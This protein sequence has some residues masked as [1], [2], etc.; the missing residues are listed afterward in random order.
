MNSKMKKIIKISNDQIQKDKQEREELLKI[1]LEFRRFIFSEEM[2]Q[3]LSLYQPQLNY[4]FKFYYKSDQKINSSKFNIKTA[5][6]KRSTLLK[7]LN[8]FYIIPNIISPDEWIILLKYLIRNENIQ[9]GFSLQEFN[10]LLVRMAIAG[11][12][13]IERW[14]TI[15]KEKIIHNFIDVQGIGIT[16]IEEFFNF[17]GMIQGIS[18]QELN[19]KLKSICGRSQNKTSNKKNGIKNHLSKFNE[20]EESNDSYFSPPTNF[21]RKNFNDDSSIRKG[22][23]LLNFSLDNDINAL[24]KIKKSSPILSNF[25]NYGNNDIENPNIQVN[26]SK[27]IQIPNDELNKENKV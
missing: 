8:D 23:N 3:L 15:D 2:H 7:L 27:S 19:F 5:T 22:S 20:S 16:T 17:M 21:V 6:L 18:K 14:K 9:D 25:Q 13:K 12:R 10:T 1:K 4:I 24:N 11:K 26:A